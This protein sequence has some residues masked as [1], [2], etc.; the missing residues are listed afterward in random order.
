MIEKDKT[1]NIFYVHCDEK[2]CNHSD[3][4]DTND[5]WAALIAEIKAD[6][7]Q[8]QNIDGEWY[9]RCPACVEKGKK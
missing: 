5:D 2:H 3:E 4:F 8:I 6:G 7:W 9:H 1:S